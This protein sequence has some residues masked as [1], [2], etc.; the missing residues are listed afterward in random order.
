MRGC[1]YLRLESATT[2]LSKFSNTDLYATFIECFALILV[3]FIS[4]TGQIKEQTTERTRRKNTRIN[5]LLLLVGFHV[6]MFYFKDTRFV[7]R[8]FIV[9]YISKRCFLELSNKCKQ[10]LN[11]NIFL[12]WRGNW[13][14]SLSNICGWWRGIDPSLSPM[15]VGGEL[16]CHPST[17]LFLHDVSYPVVYP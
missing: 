7:F 12:I 1:L 3:F 17:F 6:N 9:F 14:I 10:W 5:H 11:L 8:F 15:Y 4:D 13:P 2:R 16:C